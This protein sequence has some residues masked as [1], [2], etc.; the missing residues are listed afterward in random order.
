MPTQSV[1]S[2]YLIGLG[3]SIAPKID[4]IRSAMQ[5][6]THYFDV[7]SVSDYYFSAPAGGVATND[8]VN[9]VVLISTTISS[10][11]LMTKLLRIEDVLG[12]KRF[13]KWADRTID[14]DILVGWNDGLFLKNNSVFCT[15]PHPFFYTRDFT[16]IPAKSVL[17]KAELQ[18]IYLN[19]KGES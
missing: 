2:Y 12:R 11:N 4:H 9:A 6:M 19:F 3:S 17:R 14:L 10:E 5:E 15:I 1:N 7:I 8:F 13:K 16:V 18:G